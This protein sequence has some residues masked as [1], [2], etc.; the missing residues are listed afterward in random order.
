MLTSIRKFLLENKYRGANFETFQMYFKWKLK[1]F[2]C[3]ELDHANTTNNTH[4][5]RYAKSEIDISTRRHVGTSRMIIQV[6]EMPHNYTLD[7]Y[8]NHRCPH[9]S[10]RFKTNECHAESSERVLIEACEGKSRCLVDAKN[11]V[12]GDP[13]AGLFKYLRV[14]YRCTQPPRK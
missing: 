14:E 12:F 4:L 9:P 10:I 8:R 5:S 1:W 3:I 7:I 2:I 6:L 11:G 13:C